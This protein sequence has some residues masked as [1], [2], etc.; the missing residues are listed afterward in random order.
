MDSTVGHCR[1]RYVDIADENEI[2]YDFFVYLTENL[3][4]PLENTSY[5]FASTLSQTNTL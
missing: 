2:I 4:Y 5:I 3:Q 1:F